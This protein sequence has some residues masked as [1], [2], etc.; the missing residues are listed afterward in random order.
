MTRT[1]W[2]RAEEGAAKVEKQN[3]TLQM[4]F[5]SNRYPGET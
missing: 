1:G 5:Y 3:N 4:K 2:V